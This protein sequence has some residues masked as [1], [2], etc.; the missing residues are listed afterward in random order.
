MR[1]TR[2]TP[3]VHDVL[4]GS[5]GIAGVRT[6]EA[7][8]ITDPRFGHI[9]TLRTGAQISIQWVRSSPPSGDQSE[10]EAVVT[11]E[12]PA[13][14]VLPELPT[15]GQ[16]QL[17]L[18]EEHLV[19]LIANAASQGNPEI[20]SVEQK[21][22]REDADPRRPCCVVVRLHNGSDVFGLFRGL[23]PAGASISHGGDFQQREE[24]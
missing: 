18:V 3:W 20:K 11:G 6:F 15:S 21:S 22:V 8:G 2:W 4:E 23:A 1:L 7:E 14:R 5:P 24:V 13:S 16:T 10:E 19:A 12:P 9:L 17:R